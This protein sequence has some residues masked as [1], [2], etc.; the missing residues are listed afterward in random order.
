[1]QLVP[2]LA[3]SWEESEDKK[4]Y[5]FILKENLKWHDGEPL[6]ADDVV[7][8]FQSVK[9]PDFK[10]P[11]LI[12]F[13]GVE[14]AKIDQRTVKF[15]LPEAYPSFLELLTAGILPQHIWSDIPAVNANLT[16]FNLK[17]VGSGVWKFKSLA[18]D[19]LGNIKSFTLVPNPD[20]NGPKPYLEKITFKFYPDFETAIEALQNHS[21]DGLSFLPKNSKKNLQAMHSLNYYSFDLPQYTAVF[22]NQKKNEVLKDKTMRRILALAID[23]SNILAEA[24]QLEG[25]II[26]GPIL[27]AGPQ[28]AEDKKVIFNPEEANKLLDDAGWIKLTREDYQALKEKEARAQASSTAETASSTPAAPTATS[29]P[30]EEVTIDESQKFYRQKNGKILEIS[31]VTVDQTENVKAAELIKAAWQ[32]IGIKTNLTIV[33]AGNIIRDII[34]PRNYEVLLFGIIVGSNPDPTPFWHSSQTQDPGL[35]LAQ[36]A[37]READKLMDEA[38]KNEDIEKQKLEYQS[39]QDILAAELPAIFL[40]N[41]TYSYTADKKIKGL[42][43]K[44]ILTPADRFNNIEDWYIKTKRVWH[45]ELGS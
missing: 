39:F 12:S 36:F 25:K 33:S 9:D 5:T 21:V 2:E 19:R 29:S 32:N 18:K 7:F 37:N 17:P 44:R 35:N 40:F 31:L 1:L 42:E 11:L 43:I 10:S 38:K 8:T 3:Q 45:G 13:R 4:S 28:L 23:K 20:Y 24:L 16:E 34:K 14:I 41:P 6:T 26:D 15:T 22:F 30:E 27:P